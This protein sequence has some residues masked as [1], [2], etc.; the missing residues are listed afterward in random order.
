MLV[1]IGSFLHAAVFIVSESMVVRAKKLESLVWV[2]VLVCVDLAHV[3]AFFAML[4]SIGAV[5]SALMK[6]AQT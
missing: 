5:S 2:S 1:I 3:V 6:G 4:E